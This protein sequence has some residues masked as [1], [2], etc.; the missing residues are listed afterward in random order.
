MGLA[1]AAWGVVG[2]LLNAK[3][4]GEFS[5]PV[6]VAMIG[7][8]LMAE[9]IRAAHDPYRPNDDGTYSC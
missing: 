2:I 1:L 9:V 3:E 4:F 6:H 8:D 5:L 7:Q